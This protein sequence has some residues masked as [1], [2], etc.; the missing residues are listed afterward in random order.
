MRTRHGR[1]AARRRAPLGEQPQGRQ[2]SP[3]GELVTAARSLRVRLGDHQ[4]CSVSRRRRLDG[5]FGAI[6]KLA[7]QLEPL[8]P[9]NRAARSRASSDHRPRPAL[10]PAPRRATRFSLTTAGALGS[11]TPA[12]S[13]SRLGDMGQMIRCFGRVT[14]SCK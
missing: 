12:S 9:D 13:C 1:G 4:G 7:L 3:G 5:T 2:L 6:P 10:R 8:A 14:R 11:A